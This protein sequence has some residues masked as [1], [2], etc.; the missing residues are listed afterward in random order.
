MCTDQQ[1]NNPKYPHLVMLPYYALNGIYQTCHYFV[2]KND[3]NY[4][5]EIPVNRFQRKTLV[6]RLKGETNIFFSFQKCIP[7]MALGPFDL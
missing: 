7:T 1:Y 2:Q 6:D 3:Y 4:V 5:T